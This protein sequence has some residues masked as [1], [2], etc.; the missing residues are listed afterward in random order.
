MEN[1]F[2]KIKME[3]VN[4]IIKKNGRGVAD[5]PFIKI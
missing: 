3:D 4:E 1:Y 2:K 5:I